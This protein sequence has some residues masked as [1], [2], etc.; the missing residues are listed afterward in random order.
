MSK[1]K[2]Y[3]IFCENV[4]MLPRGTICWQSSCKRSWPKWR[5]DCRGVCALGVARAQ[6][7][8]PQFIMGARLGEAAL[9]NVFK[10]KAY[11]IIL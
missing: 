2:A 3:L 7:D 6:A 4:A 8:T 1:G 10:G 9:V 5:T 11:L